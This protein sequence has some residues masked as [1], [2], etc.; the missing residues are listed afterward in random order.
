[1]FMGCSNFNVERDTE[2]QKHQRSVGD[3]GKHIQVG[4]AFSFS[5]VNDAYNVKRAP[6]S[7]LKKGYTTPTTMIDG[8][9]KIKK[10]GK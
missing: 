6:Q 3:R 8:D 5:I 4:R 1:M 2:G 7:I 10:I 9:L